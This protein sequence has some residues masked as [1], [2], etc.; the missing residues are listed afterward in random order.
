MSTD[1]LTLDKEVTFFSADHP[2]V[3]CDSLIDG[4]REC[5]RL[6][7]GRGWSVGTSSNYSVVLSQDPVE[8]IITASGFDKGRL[9]RGDFVRVGS[10]GKPTI[11]GQPKSSAETM[12]HVVLAQR[13]E[14]VGGILHTHSV[15]ATLLSNHFFDQGGFEIVGYEMLKGLEGITTH[16]HRLWVPIFE[17]TQ[18]IQVLA[19]QVDRL[20]ETSPEKITHGFLIRRHGLYTWGRDVFAARRHV[21]IFE[22]LFEIIARTTN[23]IKK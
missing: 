2:L 23:L 5:G 16:E 9:G 20:Q 14:T 4:L 1:Q 13:P 18:D 10:N 19:S 6:F 8:L 7:H 22:F 3:G 15:W 12:L 17:N 21:E 11:S